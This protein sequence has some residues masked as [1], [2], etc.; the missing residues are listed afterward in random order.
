MR[1][2]AIYAR[3]SIEKKNSISIEGQQEMCRNAAGEEEV[4]L[5]QDRGY[6]GKNT[7]RPDFQRLLKDI[8]AGKISKIYVYRL[9]RFSRSI[10]DFSQL[11][12]TL[13]KHNVEFIS[14][15]E[16]F[17]TASPMGRAMLHI[18]MV[19]AQLERETTSERVHD[20]YAARA[21]QGAWPGGPAPYG[22]ALGRAV[23]SSGRSYA[24]LVPDDKTAAV[25]QEIF[26]LY[27]QP[28]ATLGSVVKEL[29]NRMIPGAKRD[30]WDSSTLSRMLHSPL[31]VKADEQ[32]MLHYQALGVQ[33][34]SPAEAFDGVHNAF[35]FG[36]REPNERKYTNV[37]E[38]HLTV[39]RS[40]GLVD[41]AL[42]LTVQEKLRH[43]AQV[44]NGNAGTHT[45]L[46]GLLKCAKCGYSVKIQ[47]EKEY[48]W[49]NCSGRYNNARCDATIRVNL[50]EL[51]ETVA[52]ELQELIDRC[53]VEQPAAEKD[54]YAARLEELDR[55]ADRLVDAFAESQDMSN[56]YIQRAL[57]RLEA[58]RQ[59]VLR[60]RQREK[61]RPH[62]PERVVF[63]DL[64]FDEKK[65]V[66][67]QFI[68]RVEVSEHT[69]HVEWA[70]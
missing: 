60:Q 12:K 5:Y 24:S 67:A 18:I 45:W 69:A 29:N 1:Y 11:W 40:V 26:S 34:E 70:V 56:T 66:A 50:T 68:R 54:V 51:E 37:K 33:V 42:W 31:Y 58:E 15:T 43:N 4:K 48:R 38:H 23:D 21:G 10:A 55:R 13:Q 6:S 65:L 46:T 27:A 41:A 17:D 63:N 47:T 30:F 39:L 7:D 57:Q 32:V 59:E 22:F 61:Q 64:P 8:R 14:V 25:V 35:L 16:N 28:G 20:N 53:P 19:F 52:R 44:H 49:M 9:D 62:L 3:Q 2:A 36:K